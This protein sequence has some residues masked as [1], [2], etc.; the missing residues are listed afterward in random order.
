[1]SSVNTPARK[2]SP[3]ASGSVPRH[4]ARGAVGCALI[5]GALALLSVAGPVALALVPLGLFA[6]R[7]C[8][9]CWA[10]GLMQTI[11]AGRFERDCNEGVCSLA[12]AVAAH[13]LRPSA[14]S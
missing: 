3:L 7:G 1:M 10:V 8:P 9:T 6:L 14:R 11:S 12:A 4:L 5:G 13:P 2:P